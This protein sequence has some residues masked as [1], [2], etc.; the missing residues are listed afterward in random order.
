[1]VTIP[2]FIS[3]SR[4]VTGFIFS[5]PASFDP[6]IAMENGIDIKAVTRA[7]LK[8]GAN[9]PFKTQLLFMRAD[10]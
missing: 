10:A 2:R 3:K 1:M 7:D 4:T 9:D 6:S 8:W 5:S